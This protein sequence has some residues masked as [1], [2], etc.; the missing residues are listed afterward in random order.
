MLADYAVTHTCLSME[1]TAHLFQRFILLHVVEMASKNLPRS[2]WDGGDEVIQH[3]LPVLHLTVWHLQ[4]A[5]EHLPALHRL[6]SSD[7]IGEGEGGVWKER[8]EWVNGN[9]YTVVLPL[10]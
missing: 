1:V 8:E 7:H 10:S 9:Q 2:S 5:T 4:I 6:H 3:F